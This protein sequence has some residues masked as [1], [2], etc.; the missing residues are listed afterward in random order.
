MN[1]YRWLDRAAATEIPY[2]GEP[3]DFEYLRRNPRKNRIFDADDGLVHVSYIG[4]YTLSMKPVMKAL[5]AGIGRARKWHPQL[6]TSLRL[7]FIGTD[8]AAGVDRMERVR[9]IA[10]EFGVVDLVEE[11]PARVPYLDA[12]NL[13]LESHALLVVGSVEPHYTASKIFP[14]ILAAKPLLAIF[15]EHSSVVSVLA[16][17]QA[18]QVVT[19]GDLRPASETAEEIALRFQNL[20]ELPKGFQPAVRWEAFEAYTARAMAGRLATVFDKAVGASPSR[21]A[22]Q[23]SAMIASGKQG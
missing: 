14:Y 22:V 1:R 12:L 15:H 19:F 16:E 3:R 9:P 6:F 11:H 2:G 7:H 20:L 10:A 13:L 4:A 18:G 23:T 5:F 8:Y 17:T 21:E